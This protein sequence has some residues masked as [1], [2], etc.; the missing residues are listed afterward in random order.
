MPQQDMLTSRCLHLARHV[1]IAC[2]Q[3]LNPLYVC[4]LDLP[5][6]SQD[7]GVG[8]DL[9]ESNVLWNSCRESGDHARECDATEK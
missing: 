8:G 6:L 9:I 5:L 4:S 2:M 3:Y 7:G 1:F